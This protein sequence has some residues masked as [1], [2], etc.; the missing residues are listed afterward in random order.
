MCIPFLVVSDI[1]VHITR[2]ARNIINILR[3]DMFILNA[4]L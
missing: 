3:Y 4:L 1:G 2:Y